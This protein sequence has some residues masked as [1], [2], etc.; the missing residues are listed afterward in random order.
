MALFPSVEGS[1]L[2]Q[3]Y[4]FPCLPH[5]MSLA[6]FPPP[7]FLLS[8][9]HLCFS[10]VIFCRF[11]FHLAFGGWECEVPDMKFYIFLLISI[12]F[13]SRIFGECCCDNTIVNSNDVRH[14]AALYSVHNRDLWKVALKYLFSC[15]NIQSSLSCLRLVHAKCMHIFL[16]VLS[17]EKNTGPFVGSLSAS[18]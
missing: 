16:S 17:P 15:S 2:E 13:V 18:H 7:L 4:S 11:S 14:S 8:F 12:N 5:Q 3:A 9:S 6:A 10:P 1:G